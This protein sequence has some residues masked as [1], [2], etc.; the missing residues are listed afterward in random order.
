MSKISFYVTVLEDGNL[1]PYISDNS[2]TLKRFVKIDLSVC[3]HLQQNLEH[4]API[5]TGKKS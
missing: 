2:I 5:C 1:Q 3:P 4:K